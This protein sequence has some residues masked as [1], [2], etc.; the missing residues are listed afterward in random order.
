MPSISLNAPASIR[1]GETLVLDATVENPEADELSYSLSMTP[2]LNI[3]RGG[4]VCL[5]VSGTGTVIDRDDLRYPIPSDLLNEM[6][7]STDVD[8]VLTVEEG[9]SVVSEMVRLT[10]VK[11]NNGVISLSAPMLNDFTY[12]IDVDLS[13]DS[14]GVN[15]T[16]EIAYQWQRELLD[17]WSD[18]DDATDAS[19]TAEGIIGDRYRVLVDYTDKQAIGI[20]ASYLRRY[21]HRNNSMWRYLRMF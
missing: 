14:D 5:P 19:Y 1:E 17:S 6:Q 11:E 18:I 21:R 7:S 8:I 16:P 10:I 4:L 13:S 12:I 2:N 15:P 20:K 9:L 3:C